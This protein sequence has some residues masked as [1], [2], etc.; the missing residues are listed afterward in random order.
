[1]Y[2][3]HVREEAL[4][5]LAQGRSL[6]AVGAALG[7]SRSAL[8]EWRDR[9]I[10]PRSVSSTCPR[11]ADEMLED[12]ESYVLL[13]GYYLGDGCISASRGTFALRVSCDARYPG[14]IRAVTNAV[15][16][17]HSGGK[18][19]H[20]AAP[21]CVVVKN[22]WKHWPCLFP[23]HGPGRKDQ[24]RLILEPWQQV[25][26]ERHPAAFVR[27]LFHSDGCRFENWTVKTVAGKRKRYTYPRWMFT[28]HSEEIRLWCTYALDLLGIPWRQPYWKT[29][30]V[31]RRDGVAMMDE[32]VGPKS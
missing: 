28:N 7:V 13:F 20:V 15:E 22:S 3:P 29:I 10:E 30:A 5:L 11:C 6:N 27:G 19:C 12:A 31:S 18:A 25:L 1:M 4:R 9:G 8:R 21:G 26:V 14:I 24:R 32:L 17:V 2:P 23:Q 16:A